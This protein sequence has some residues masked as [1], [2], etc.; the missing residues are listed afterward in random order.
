M[1]CNYGKLYSHKI[2]KLNVSYGILAPKNIFKEGL[3]TMNHI[4]IYLRKSIFAKK[5]KKHLKS[6]YGIKEK[7]RFWKNSSG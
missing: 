6:V 3:A 7:N 1:T 4:E 5:N 2:Y